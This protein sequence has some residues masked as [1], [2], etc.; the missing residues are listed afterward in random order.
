MLQELFDGSWCSGPQKYDAP[1]ETN[2][3][4]HVFVPFYLSAH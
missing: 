1:M 3:E 4:T 2:T